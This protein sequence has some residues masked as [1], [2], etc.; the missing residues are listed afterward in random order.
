MFK[1][2]EKLYCY[3]D[4]FKKVH[5]LYLKQQFPSTIL[6]S[7]K[8][9]C[10]K[11]NFVTHLLL[12]ILKNREFKISLKNS[13][14]NLNYL[15]ANKNSNVRYIYKK[16]DSLNITIEQIREISNYSK[17]SSLDGNSKFI[18]ICNA[19]DLNMNAA[20][21]LLQ[22]LENPPEN[23]FFLLITNCENKIIN[24]VKS[25][26]VKFKISFSFSKNK[27]ILDSLLKDHE[28]TELINIKFFNKFDT[29]GV[30]IDKIFFIKNNNLEKSSILEIINFCFDNF[31]KTKNSKYL[32]YAL[33][34]S[35]NYFDQK[36]KLNFRRFYSSYYLFLYK[37]LDCAKYGSDFSSFLNL[38]KKNN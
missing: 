11:K 37:C 10:G 14:D 31:K 34:F 20:N 22:T 21:A 13:I 27:L 23:T 17:Q 9:G 24:T 12:H 35:A 16:D 30:I 2:H 7:G 5:N 29:P 3:D 32:K 4:Y 25:R 26:C 8:E 36:L 33:D 38:L 1:F 6:F 28:L 18:V 19:E 15:V